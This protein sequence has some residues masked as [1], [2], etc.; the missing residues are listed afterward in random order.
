MPRIH[1]INPDTA[2][3]KAKELLDAVQGA[4]GMTPNMAR[5]MARNPAVLEGWFALNSA[6][7]TTLSRG[8]NEQIAIAVAEANECI[9]CLSGHTAFGRLVGVDDHE[10]AL[11]R[12]GDSSDPKVAAALGFART[13][14]AKRGALSDD[15]LARIR[16]AG[17]DDGEIAAILAQVGLNVF[18]NYFN[19]VTRPVVDFPEITPGLAD[20]A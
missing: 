13:V 15:D 18:T 19:L 6:L 9:Y 3:G 16:A 10:L 5:T 8:I 11:S 2:T 17:W 7:G 4:L 20:A 1:P 12:A 14:N